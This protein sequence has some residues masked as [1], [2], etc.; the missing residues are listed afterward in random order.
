MTSS[1]NNTASGGRHGIAMLM[2]PYSRYNKASP[3]TKQNIDGE[4]IQFEMPAHGRGNTVSPK[5]P[6]S[7][8][9]ILAFG[10]CSTFVFIWQK[11]SNYKLIR[12]KRFVSR[13]LG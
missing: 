4:C 11:L 5:A 8:K 1:I 3:V 12:L 6:F 10:Y 13:F 7:C 9:K 2:F